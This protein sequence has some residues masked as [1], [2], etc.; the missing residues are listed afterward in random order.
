MKNVGHG[1]VDAIL[2]G[3]GEKP[4]DDLNEFAH[5]V[6]LR[7]VGERALESLIK[8]GALDRFGPRLALLEGLDRIVAVSAGHFKAKEQGQLSL[9]GALRWG[10]GTNR[11]SPNR[12]RSQ[13]A[14]NVELET[15]ELIGLYV[16]DHPLSPVLNELNQAVTHFS[17]QLGEAA[18]DDRVRVAG[19]ITRVRHHQTRTGKPMGFV[20]L[21]DV[22]GAIELVVFPRIWTKY[23][24]LIVSDKIVL[25]DGRVDAQGAEPKVLVDEISTDFTMIESTV[26][27][28]GPL[29]DEMFFAW[30]GDPDE[31][32]ENNAPAAQ[33]PSGSSNRLQSLNMQSLN[34]RLSGLHR[35]ST[36]LL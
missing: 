20:T 11:P 12:K 27:Q 6:D 33:T 10:A 32:E 4:F 14:R 16:S 9:F 22:Q 23:A 24:D 2:A 26:L 5:R 17:G 15:R 31:I 19:L 25:V 7:Q 1:P 18:Q 28:S 36:P 30:D 13:P 8:V 3:R 35:I 29:V 21:E 34:S